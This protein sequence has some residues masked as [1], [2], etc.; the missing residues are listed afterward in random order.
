MSINLELYK[1]FY[2]AVTEMSIS[3]AAKK[4]YITQP[5][6]SQSIHQLEEILEVKLFARSSKGIKL[7]VEGSELYKYIEPSYNF[8][9]SAEE[10]IKE[11]KRL[12]AGNV[13][14]GASD[15]LCMYYLPDFL[16]IFKNKYPKIK[17]KISNRTTNETIE[18]LK[19]G[20]VDFGII[21]LPVE[22]NN[23]LEITKVLKIRDVF[24][25][26]NDYRNLKGRKINPEELIEYPMLLL[27]KGTSTRSH[28]EN[29]AN[30]NK[31]KLNPEI[32]LA[33]IDLLKKFAKIG[34]GISC[35]VKNFIIEDIKN[36]DLFE[37][38]LSKPIPERNIGIVRLKNVPMSIAANRFIELI[39]E[40]KE[41]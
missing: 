37:I 30:E 5:A 28:I 7:T 41:K 24:V 10:K 14:I 39:M 31:I 27:E 2:Y 19:R 15:T 20:V 18:L 6:V 12:E 25:A 4:L 40:E 29:W 33:S 11:R 21:N 1:V 3:K 23:K 36:D 9:L 8:I 34:M 22:N 13:S 17:L 38:K 32:E 26:N 16:K 35:V